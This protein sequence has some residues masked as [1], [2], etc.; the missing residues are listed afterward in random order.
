MFEVLLVEVE[1][2]AGESNHDSASVNGGVILDRL[3]FLSKM[4][5]VA[6]YSVMLP[7]DLLDPKQQ[8]LPLTLIR[9]MGGKDMFLEMKGHIIC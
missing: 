1:A 3:H 8:F 4:Q 2:V 9:I 7:F 5:F 6:G